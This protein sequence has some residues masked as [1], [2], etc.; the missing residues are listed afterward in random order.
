[1]RAP[2]PLALLYLGSLSFLGLE[3]ARLDFASDAHRKW[4]KGEPQPRRARR[5]LPPTLGAAGGSSASEAALLPPSWPPFVGPEET[6]VPQASQE[7]KEEEEEKE[8]VHLRVKRYRQAPHALGQ[9]HGV[10]TGC[11]L[12]TCNTANL[13]HKIFHLTDKDKDST[14]PANKLSAHGYGRRKRR[15]RRRRRRRE[16]QGSPG[17]PMPLGQEPLDPFP[18]QRR[19]RRR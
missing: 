4:T 6:P 16:L 19:R 3:A 5:E 2:L 10:R 9:L 18:Q 13:A 11:R 8:E 1:M 15:R 17:T 7:E 14:A 12:G